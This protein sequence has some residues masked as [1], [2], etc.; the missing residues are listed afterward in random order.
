MAKIEHFFYTSEESDETVRRVA[1]GMKQ[2]IHLFKASL[3]KAKKQQKPVIATYLETG[4]QV[5]I[6]SLKEAGKK[7]HCSAYYAIKTGKEIKGY[8]LSYK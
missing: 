4:E 7:L 2:G 5:E 1:K 3:D 6:K 8:K